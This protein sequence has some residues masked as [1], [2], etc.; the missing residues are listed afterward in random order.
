MAAGG[1]AVKLGAGLEQSV[2]G[3]LT[4]YGFVPM[5]WSEFNYHS[6]KGTLPPRVV[7]KG[8]RYTGLN[9]NPNSQVDWAIIENNRI[10]AAVEVKSQAGSGS[11][12]RKMIYAAL[13]A[14]HNTLPGVPM[15]V[16]GGPM[17]AKKTH[18]DHYDYDLAK[19]IIKKGYAMCE[20]NP[21]GEWEPVTPVKP[22]KYFN[23]DE[24]DKWAHDR[25][26]K[27]QR[28]R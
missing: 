18:G 3:T 6:D 11:T 22:A 24:F 28:M 15:V 17:Q 10:V 7:V 23:R 8:F 9:G 1:T 4:N 5:K 21:L 12:S 25:F 16:V 2:I 14:R 27:P 26:H 20:M 19:N 13:D